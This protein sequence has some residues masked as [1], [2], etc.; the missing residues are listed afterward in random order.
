VADRPGYD[1][2]YASNCDKLKSDWAGGSNGR[3][4]AG[5]P[6]LPDT[7]KGRELLAITRDLSYAGG[8]FT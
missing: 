3:S 2:R 4:R 6:T 1:R 5:L 7:R 8:A